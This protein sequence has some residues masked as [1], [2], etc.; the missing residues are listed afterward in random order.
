[1]STKLGAERISFVRMK[2]TAQPIHQL[3]CVCVCVC[4]KEGGG[5]SGVV[6][7]LWYVWFPIDFDYFQNP[8]K[9]IGIAPQTHIHAVLINVDT[10]PL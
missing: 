4:G 8:H 7:C 9:N 10:G 3:V 1:M 2:H 5:G 6:N